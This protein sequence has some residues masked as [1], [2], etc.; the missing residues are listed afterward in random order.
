MR[1]APPDDDSLG[2][3]QF[4]VRPSVGGRPSWIQA[5]PAG[6]RRRGV[7]V[8]WYIKDEA[9]FEEKPQTFFHGIGP[10]LQSKNAAFLAISSPA[11]DGQ[12]P[13][14]SCN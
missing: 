1:G 4:R 7:N 2:A 5:H 3:R 14:V 6:A 9:G 13:I 11:V 12:W 8:R 10:H